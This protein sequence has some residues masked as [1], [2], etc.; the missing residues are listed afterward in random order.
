M[1]GTLKNDVDFSG[2]IIAPK[3]T[4]DMALSIRGDADMDD[5]E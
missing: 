2:V 4:D 5:V 1:I 3:I